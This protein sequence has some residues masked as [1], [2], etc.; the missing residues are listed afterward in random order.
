MLMLAERP[1]PA[2]AGEV[3]VFP[4]SMCAT[5]SRHSMEQKHQ[6]APRSDK[7]WTCALRFSPIAAAC[8]ER[9]QFVRGGGAA[10]WWG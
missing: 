10:R 3:P 5:A 8:V 9:K 2:G 1:V 7:A 4:S 6:S